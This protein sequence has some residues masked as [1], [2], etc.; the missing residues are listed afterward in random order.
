MGQRLGQHFLKDQSV[1]RD[2][3]KALEIK[4]GD[5]VI[6]IG[7][8]HG[9]LTGYLLASGAHVVAIEKDFRLAPQLKEHFLP[10]TFRKG[11]L[12]V[13]EGDA[14]EEIERLLFLQDLNKKDYKCAGNIPYY[15]TGHL[16]RI[17]G[18]LPH[19]PKRT[20]FTIQKEVAQRVCSQKGNM[21][22]IAACVQAWA[23]PLLVRSIRPG[24]FSPPP[25]V[26]SA[27]LLLFAE[28]VLEFE[29]VS[30]RQ[31][32]DIARI[33]FK[34]PRKTIMNNLL[35]GGLERSLVLRAFDEKG[36]KHNARPAT[37]GVDDIVH[38]SRCFS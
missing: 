28:D 36:I 21:N 32:C 10:P 38:I 11:S 26:D 33:I 12:E 34:Q 6:E 19:R 8:G 25:K 24:S 22:L 18:N 20:V 4:P 27:I 2:V 7:P 31:Y 1:L 16:L 30:F 23:K 14:L 5:F 13:I 15:I 3:A 17:I 29:G 35:A 37:L 9:E